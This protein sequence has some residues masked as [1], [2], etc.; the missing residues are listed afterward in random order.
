MLDEM[1]VIKNL[2][3]QS[4]LIPEDDSTSPQAKPSMDI[5]ISQDL[6]SPINKSSI[7]DVFVDAQL[8]QSVR[9][10]PLVEFA[11]VNSD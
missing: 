10:E 5:R 4:S 11:E 8:M 6:H 1:P 3:N 7:V 9:V 2:I